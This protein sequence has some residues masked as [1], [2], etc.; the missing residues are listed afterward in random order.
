RGREN[1]KLDVLGRRRRHATTVEQHRSTQRQSQSRGKNPAEARRS[2][3]HQTAP[4]R[5]RDGRRGGC[6]TDVPE[7]PLHV[8]SRLKARGRRLFKETHHDGR[9][10]GR[11]PGR[12][13]EIG[14]LI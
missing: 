11:H 1:W 3:S 9:E 4:P 14:G 6:P 8:A 13:Q 7:C 12:L 5:L 2:S 10:V